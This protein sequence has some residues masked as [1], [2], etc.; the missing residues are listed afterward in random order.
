MSGEG[1]R[2]GSGLETWLARFPAGASPLPVLVEPLRTRRTPPELF[3]LIA[4]RP[5]AF[6]LDSALDVSGQGNYTYFGCEPV[7]VLRCSGQEVEFIAGR[8][9]LTWRGD[10]F[11][12]VEYLLGA[13]RSTP[14]PGA[15]PFVGGL[16]GYF[17]YDLR[18]Q[19]ERL[20][21]RTP[22]DLPVPDLVVGL[23]DAIVAHDHGSGQTFLC[24]TGYPER[25]PNS[26]RR[27][28]RQRIHWL[29]NQFGAVEM[30]RTFETAR[31]LG[32]SSNFTRDGYLEAVE[33]ALEYIAAGD[34][35]QVNLSQRFAAPYPADPLPLYYRLRE[36]SPAPFAA[37][38][39]Y[40]DIAVLSSSPERLLRLDGRHV[41]TRPIKGTRPRGQ[42]PEEDQ[43]LAR[44]LWESPKDHAELVMIVDLERNDL[45]RVCEYGSVQVTELAAL[46][47][48]PT[49]FH[50]VATVEGRL[51]KGVLATDCLRAC[52]P[53]GSITGAPKVRAMEIIE[54]LE[55]TRRG[56]YTGA[57]GYLGWN[58]QVD[59]NIA[60]RTMVVSHRRLTFHV[61]GGIVADSEPE[62]EYQ[63]TLDKAQGMLRALQG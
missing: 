18:D 29:R 12:A 50:L 37:F 6:L 15:P 31:L 26:S 4:H 8:E 1:L 52:F 56:V 11:Q 30:P 25:E 22:A 46:E 10:S 41:Q 44:A 16:V 34:I 40:G 19:V 38:L 55:P 21:R 59:L 48:H 43:R 61:G 62:A 5:Y 23:Y 28:A 3:D 60:I 58:G 49:V 51:R 35:Y 17:A 2:A 9:R 33:R 63:E 57:I 32:L 47:A 53:G 54:E 45:G 14:P 39:R 13:F 36:A 27:W 42:T 20:A 7:A 24:S